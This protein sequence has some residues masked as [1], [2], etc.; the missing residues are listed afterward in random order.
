MYSIKYLG[1]NYRVYCHCHVLN[2]VVKRTC[3]PY[4]ES[5]LSQAD[6]ELS[7]ALAAALSKLKNF[8]TA[9]RY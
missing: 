3:A 7:M 9:A 1:R 8:V 4:A 6:H 5:N 2:T